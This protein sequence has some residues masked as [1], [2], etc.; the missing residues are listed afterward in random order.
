M[1]RRPPDRKT[2]ALYLLVG[3][4]IVALTSLALGS[5]GWFRVLRL[6][7]VYGAV[8]LGLIYVFQRVRRR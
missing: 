5:G 4:A 2:I 6:L 7:V 8:F 1:S 3:L